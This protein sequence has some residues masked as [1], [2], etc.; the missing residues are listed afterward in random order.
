[1]N[2]WPDIILVAA[3]GSV[4]SLFTLV[5]GFAFGRLVY[6]QNKESDQ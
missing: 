1:M 2:C 6:R 3:I 4:L 5:A